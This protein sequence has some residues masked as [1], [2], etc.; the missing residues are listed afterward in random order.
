MG[1]ILSDYE[2]DS[3]KDA[4]NIAKHKGVSLVDAN[5]FEWNTASI[6]EDHRKQYPERRFQATGYIGNRLF[7][8][9]F[10]IRGIKKR[11]I[12]LRKANL[13]EEKSYA[14]TKARTP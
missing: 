6:Q 12:S 7:V 5:D 10:C 2:F 1:T 4:I 9:V 13:R 14:K 3:L 8:M 11:V